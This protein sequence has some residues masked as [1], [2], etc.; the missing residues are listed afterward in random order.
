MPYQSPRAGVV[1]AEVTET[2]LV[3]VPSSSSVPSTR[4]SALVVSRPPA[5]ESVVAKRMRELGWKVRV[6]PAVMTTSPLASVTEPGAKIWLVYQ[7]PWRPAPV[8]SPA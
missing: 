8:G 6:A 5:M 4:S 3:L 2:L 7:K 1:A